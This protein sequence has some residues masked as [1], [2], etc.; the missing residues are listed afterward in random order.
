MEAAE[1][2]HPHGLASAV[3]RFKSHQKR[4]GGDEGASGTEKTAKFGCFEKDYQ[5][6]VEEVDSRVFDRFG[7]IHEKTDFC[8][9][10]KLR[11]LYSLLITHI[12]SPLPCP[13]V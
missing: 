9:H 13:K 12:L 10:R 7:L 3:A 5:G 11:R 8:R 4:L 1:K 6:R 2:R